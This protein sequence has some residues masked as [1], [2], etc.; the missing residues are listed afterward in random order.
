M[1]TITR[2]NWREHTTEP[3]LTAE[4]WKQVY[5]MRTAC[6]ENEEMSRA[7]FAATASEWR[8]LW[9]KDNYADGWEDW[10]DVTFWTDANVRLQRAEVRAWEEILS[11]V[12]FVT[13][14]K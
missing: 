13:R 14:N 1:T 9:D 2:H 11:Y 4:E 3:P 7:V 6:C 12:T 10:E 5:A 8:T